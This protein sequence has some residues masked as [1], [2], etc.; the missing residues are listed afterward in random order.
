MRILLFLSLIT[1]TGCQDEAECITQLQ[2]AIDQF[3]ITTNQY[4][5]DDSQRVEWNLLALEAEADLAMLKIMDDRNS[6]D[7]EFVSGKLR[8]K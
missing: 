4:A 1:L 7:Y 2:S 3:R 5:R 6:C 8:L